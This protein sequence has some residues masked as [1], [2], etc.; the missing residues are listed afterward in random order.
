MAGDSAVGAGVDAGALCLLLPPAKKMSPYAPA[1]PPMNG[2][3]PETNCRRLS[4]TL[5]GFMVTNGDPFPLERS[6]DTRSPIRCDCCF[7]DDGPALIVA[8][9][10]ATKVSSVNAPNDCLLIFSPDRADL[11]NSLSVFRDEITSLRPLPQ[12]PRHT[13]CVG[14]AVRR[15]ADAARGAS[16][17]RITPRIARTAALR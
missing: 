10:A 11:W 9:A 16:T 2:L 17:A 13:S 15:P 1:P 6:V 3:R 7:W 14:T 4:D 12:D 5:Q 8:V